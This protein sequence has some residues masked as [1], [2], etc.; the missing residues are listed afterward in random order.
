MTEADSMPVSL[1]RQ[2]AYCPRIPFFR[3]ALGLSP[4]APRWVESGTGYDA[5]QDALSGDRRFSSMSAAKMRPCRRVSLSDPVLRIHGIADL[6]LL[7]DDRL[8]ACDYKLEARR[9]ERGARLQLAAYAIMAERLYGLPCEALIVLTGKPMRLLVAKWSAELRA[10]VE[11]AIG[12]VRAILEAGILPASDAGP[13][14]CGI[15]EYLNYCNDR[16]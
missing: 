2:W 10:E 14:K 4:V 5:V 11:A 3:E 7:V 8:Y 15:C 1:L 6:I 13:E 12:Q 16:A 9:I